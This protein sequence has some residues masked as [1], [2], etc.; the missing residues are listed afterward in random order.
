MV[1]FAHT[2][3][4]THTRDGTIPPP[5]PRDIAKIMYIISIHVV[6]LCCIVLA[7]TAMFGDIAWGSAKYNGYV[8]DICDS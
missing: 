4:L 8:A 7:Q 6:K 1:H 2:G 5:M 3:G